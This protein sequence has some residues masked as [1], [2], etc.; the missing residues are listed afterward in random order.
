MWVRRNVSYVDHSLRRFDR[1][2]W[3]RS[4]GDTSSFFSPVYGL[5]CQIVKYLAENFVRFNISLNVF[6]KE[7][8]LVFNMS[9]NKMTLVFVIEKLSICTFWLNNI[10]CN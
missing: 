2:R 7:R 1:L 9:M 10:L 4:V 6:R 8:N 5:Q 3:V